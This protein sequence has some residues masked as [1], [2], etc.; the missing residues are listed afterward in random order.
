MCKENEKPRHLQ[1]EVGMVP[2][3]ARIIVFV[4]TKRQVSPV[5]IGSHH[6]LHLWFHCMTKPSARWVVSASRVGVLVWSV[7]VLQLVVGMVPDDARMMLFVNT[8]RQVGGLQR[9]LAK[10]QTSGW[11]L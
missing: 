6:F 3:D 8:K 10:C 9:A 2:D 7:L 4:N 5:Y 11:R 1:Q